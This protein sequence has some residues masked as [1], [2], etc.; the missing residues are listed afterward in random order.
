MENLIVKTDKYAIDNSEYLTY[1]SRMTTFQNWPADKFPRPEQLAKCGFYHANSLSAA[2]KTYCFYC[3]RSKSDW[4]AFD[5]PWVEHAILSAGCPFLL[6]NRSSQAS[7]NWNSL[8]S[9]AESPSIF[10]ICQVS[11]VFLNLQK[12]KC[13]VRKR[14]K[15][16]YIKYKFYSFTCRKKSRSI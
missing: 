13:F 14:E 3:G 6:L 4:G 7:F 9:L 1:E 10:E 8:V 5:N 15:N 12:K 11:L 16:G 2:T